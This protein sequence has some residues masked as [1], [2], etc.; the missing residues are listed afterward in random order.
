MKSIDPSMRGDSTAPHADRLIAALATRQHGVIARLQLL[1]L[2]ISGHAIDRRVARGQL[3]VIHR[4]IYAVGH[5]ALTRAGRWT[6]AVL[7]AGEGA[8]LSH[9][10]AGAGLR[11][12]SW[13]GITHVT[14]PGTRRRRPGIDI[15]Q[16]RGLTSADVCIVDGIPTTTWARTLIDLGAVLPVDRLARALEQAAIARL[17]DDAELHAAMDR[18]QGHRGIARLRTALA[19]GD[20][21]MPQQVRSPLE[22]RFLRLVRWAD[23]PLPPVRT[24]VWLPELGEVDA[25]WAAE[26]VAVELDSAR[27]HAHVGARERDAAKTADLQAAGFHVVRLRWDDVTARPAPTLRRLREL[28]NRAGGT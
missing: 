8:T 26:R 24:N 12:I 21:L 19:R 9:Q 25:L 4:G 14:A 20:H 5:S 28:L 6:A 3:I 1:R 27:F 15:H 17:Y 10:S 23:P 22:E 2:G 11:I 7:A 13:D 16:S 18:A